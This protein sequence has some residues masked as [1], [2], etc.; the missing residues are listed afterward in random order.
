MKMVPYLSQIMRC[1]RIYTSSNLFSAQ[2]KQHSNSMLTHHFMAQDYDRN[3]ELVN[4]SQGLLTDNLPIYKHNREFLQYSEASVSHSSKQCSMSPLTQKKMEW[5]HGSEGSGDSFM[6]YN[7]HST[8]GNMRRVAVADARE[9]HH[10][11]EDALGS[12]QDKDPAYTGEV[13]V[14]FSQTD[15][16]SFLHYFR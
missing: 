5:E 11:R 9:R 7:K 12:F 6:H 3:Q 15:N 1:I 4:T 13:L 14:A 2:A 10:L 8:L 16:N